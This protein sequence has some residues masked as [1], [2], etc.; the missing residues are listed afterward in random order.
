MPP[1]QK[2][3]RLVI[4]TSSNDE[5]LATKLLP[6]Q[7]TAPKDSHMV[8]D[9]Q[10]AESNGQTSSKHNRMNT[11]EEEQDKHLQVLLGVPVMLQEDD[12]VS[13]G[14]VEAQPSHMGG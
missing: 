7:Q 11:A 10:H 12:S 3:F 1:C 9:A 14:E 4:G 8:T 2:A 5:T 6:R 13:R